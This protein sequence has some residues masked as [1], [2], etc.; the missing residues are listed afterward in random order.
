VREDVSAKVAGLVR[1][2]HDAQESKG[3]IG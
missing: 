1:I 2:R 3:H